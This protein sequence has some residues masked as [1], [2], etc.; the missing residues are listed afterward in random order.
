[1]SDNPYDLIMPP[2]AFVKAVDA[3]IDAANA[4]FL[5]SPEAQAQAARDGDRWRHIRHAE[6][7]AGPFA[8]VLP[9]RL[10]EDLLAM[11]RGEPTLLEQASEGLTERMLED[12]IRKAQ[13]RPEV[14]HKP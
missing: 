4:D 11:L 12:H 5:A 3:A 7:A 1:M 13:A 2:G 10:A 6:E 14:E 8:V 9:V